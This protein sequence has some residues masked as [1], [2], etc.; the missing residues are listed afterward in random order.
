MSQQRNQKL[1]PKGSRFTTEDKILALSIFKQS[2]RCYRYLSQIFSLPSRRTLTYLLSKV[3]FTPGINTHIFAQLKK[4]VTKMT[5]RSKY[6][7]LMF[8][9][10]S[11]QPD[12][13]YN[14]TD[15][16]IEGLVD[17]GGSERSIGFADHALVFMLKGIYKKW[18]QSICYTFCVNATPM[19]HLVKLIKDIVRCVRQVGL[20]IV[21]TI[22]DQG[23]T[24]V[25]AINTLLNDTRSYCLRNNIENRYQGYLIDEEEVIH[26]YDPPHLLKGV[27]NSLLCQDLHFIEEG[28]EKVASWSHI[29]DFYRIDK[30]MGKFSQFTKLTDEHVVPDRIQKMKVKKC[31]QVFSTTVATAMKVRAVISSELTPA[32]RFYLDSRAS[33]TAD[34]LLFFDSLFDSVNGSLIN[35]PPGKSLRGLVTR[36]S[37]H[38]LTWEK[39]LEILSK[40]YF[41]LPNSRKQFIPPSIKNW[42]FTIRGFIYIWKKMSGMGCTS[43][44]ARAFNQDPV[45]N[46]FSCIRGYGGRNINPTCTAFVS[47]LKSLIINNCK[48]RSILL[49]VT[50]RKINQWVY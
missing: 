34:L 33:D 17:F 2:G 19:V 13:Q 21:A 48:F 45:E 36:K 43:L 18:K 4:T 38:L 28:K 37:R 41:T 47:T 30:E 20:N 26:L 35:P 44:A 23:T 31:T 5:G 15:D 24:N 11:L 49:G 16:C 46:L 8:D 3:H 12:L 6:C 27:R 40:M 32:S 7:V 39:A 22:C 10:I 25:A 14:P 42:I 29:M 1:Q 9:E 50:V